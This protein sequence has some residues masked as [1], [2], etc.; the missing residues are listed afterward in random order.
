MGDLKEA[1]V[2]GGSPE[3][4]GETAGAP[5]AAAAVGRKIFEMAVPGVETGL[6][7]GERA[8]LRIGIGAGNDTVTLREIDLRVPSFSSRARHWS[9]L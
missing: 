8:V 9:V 3:G 5:S 4:S 2:A 1:R 7:P 6:K